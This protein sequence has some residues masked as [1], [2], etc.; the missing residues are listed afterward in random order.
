MRAV[1]PPAL[2]PIV[3]GRRRVF[4]CHRAVLSRKHPPNSLAA[5]REC[6]EAGVPRAEIDVRFLSD[7]SLLVFHDAVLEN[8]TLGTGSVA[9]LDARA[10]R[11]LRYRDASQTSLAFLDEVVD[12]IR[13]SSLLLQV[14]LKATQPLS[15]AQTTTLARA[16][17]PVRDHVLVGSQAHWNLRFLGAEGFRIAFD[18]T[19]HWR[20]QEGP[21]VP[22]TDPKR[23]GL[24]GLWDDSPLAHLAGV[25]RAEY[26]SARI[27]DL[28][29]LIDVEE[30]MVD[31]ETLFFLA[32]NQLR[33][34]EV[35]R[36]N[37]V[38]LAAWTIP[39][40]GHEANRAMLGRLFDIGVETIISK[41]PVELARD[42][43]A[44]A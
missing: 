41:S 36:A 16:L 37:G 29:G 8:D 43:A 32:A 1:E 4:C 39:D 3:A 21:H 13:G 31:Y 10:A 25:D 15:P 6:V 19:L 26:L 9:A 17:E 28:L 2:D 42:A 34:G 20:Y 23:R 40:N 22:G 5:I 27:D 12:T 11:L 7:D 30:W 18:P 44:L 38:A 14:D 33:L 35:L 24:H